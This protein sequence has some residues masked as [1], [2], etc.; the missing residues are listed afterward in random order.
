MKDKTLSFDDFA[1]DSKEKV[2]KQIVAMISDKQIVS[3]LEGGKRLRSILAGLSFKACTQGKETEAQYQ[4]ALEGGV[5]IELA[6]GASLV[7]DDI[8]DE[9][10]IRRGKPSF[11]ANEGVASALLMGHK[12]LV[13]GFNIALRHGTKVAELYINSWNELVSGEI[14]EVNI[15]KKSMN[16]KKMSTK[17]QIFAAYNKI[18]DL[19]T[20][21]LFSSACKAGALEADMAGDILKVFSDYGRE[22]GLAYQLADDLVDLA[23][24]EMIDSVIIPLLSRLENKKVKIG[25]LKKREIKRRFAKNKDKIQEYYIEEINKHIRNAEEISKSDLIPKSNYKDLLGYAPAY[26]INK[27]L[28]EINVTI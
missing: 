13:S 19:K 11:H 14:D 2:E 18:I 28:K 25:F 20:A 7:H 12:M 22:I 5:V 15:N 4:K 16:L 6:H 21:A 8:I 17:E 9:D 26:I 23:N 1:E 10:L 27:M 24:G 3:I